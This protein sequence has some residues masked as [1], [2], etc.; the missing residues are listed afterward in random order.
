MIR[1]GQISDK[2]LKTS[3]GASM[4]LGSISAVIRT[5]N[6]FEDDRFFILKI[7]SILILLSSVAI[8]PNPYTV[9][10]GKTAIAPRRNKGTALSIKCGLSAFIIKRTPLKEFSV[11]NLNFGRLVTFTN[12]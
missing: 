6:G 8:V 3:S 12:S 1:A 7:L 9:S 5:L 2:A 10:V 11:K 4:N